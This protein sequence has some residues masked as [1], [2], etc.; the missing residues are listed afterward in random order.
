MRYSL[1][2]PFM[3]RPFAVF[4]S[5]G[6]DN[7]GVTPTP[8]SGGGKTNQDKINEI[9]DE[10][11]KAGK[12]VEW[13]DEL[14]KL[15]KNR[16]AVFEETTTVAPAPAPKKKKKKTI[17]QVSSTGQYAGDGFE[18]VDSDQGYLTR[19]YTGE[20]K[21]NNLGKDV[22]TGGTAPNELKETIAAISLNEGS[23]FA[24]SVSSATDRDILNVLRGEEI[25]SPSYA[26][27]VGQEDYQDPAP[28]PVV[29]YTP[30]TPS[31]EESLRP[32]ARPEDVFALGD[33]AAAA[34]DY[35]ILDPDPEEDLG[36]G[37][38]PIST[39][40]GQVTMDPVTGEI[41]EYGT[42]EAEELP[43]FTYD[44]RGPEQLP[45][46]E[47]K[48]SSLRPVVSPDLDTLDVDTLLDGGGFDLDT[49][50]FRPSTSDFVEPVV[51]VASTDQMAGLDQLLAMQE[52]RDKQ[53][54]LKRGIDA[55][56]PGLAS[57]L[58]EAARPQEASVG[59]GII[60]ALKHAAI[61]A[62]ENVGSMLGGIGSYLETTAPLSLFQEGGP[63]NVNPMHFLADQL[64]KRLIPEEDRQ[65]LLLGADL[66][67]PPS[68]P[69]QVLTDAGSFLRDTASPAI[70]EFL[71]PKSGKSAVV[72]DTFTD[73]TVQDVGDGE[74]QTGGEAVQ[75]LVNTTFGEAADVGLDMLLS[76]NPVTRVGSAALNAGE[77]LT[78]FQEA[79]SRKIDQS[80]I[81]GQLD[82]NPIY[83]KALNLQNGD[84]DKALQVVKNYSYDKGYPQIVAAGSLD[85]VIPGVS[86]GNALYS[87]AK[88]GLK[89]GAVEGAQGSFESYTAI[90]SINKALGT[91]FDVT[92]NIVGQGITEGLA[93]AGVG[94]AVG[95]GLSHLPVSQQ[96]QAADAA[97]GN[98][99]APPGVGPSAQTDPNPVA[100]A[101]VVQTGVDPTQFATSGQLASSTVPT[102]FDDPTVDTAPPDGMATSM[103]IMAAQEIIDNSIAETGTVPVE[104]MANLQTATG[105]SM[106]LLNDMAM[107]STA[108]PPD[109]T[110]PSDLTD[111]VT[112]IG[113][114][115]NVQVQPLPS[116]ETMLTNTATG[117]QELVPEGA[118]LANAI[119]VFD[120]VTTPGLGPLDLTSDMRAPE[121]ATTRIDP[122]P[123]DLSGIP[124]RL[125]LGGR[126]DTV[127]SV[128]PDAEVAM[129]VPERPASP[130]VADMEPRINLTDAVSL[131]PGNIAGT[132]DVDLSSIPSRLT[133]TD[134]KSMGPVSD[135]QQGI[136]SLIDM[137][138]KDYADLEAEYGTG[139]RPGW[140]SAELASIQQDISALQSQDAES[141]P[142]LDETPP[143][144]PAP[145]IDQQPAP[146]PISE[147]DIF[148]VQVGDSINGF[149]VADTQ[150]FDGKARS[151]NL[152]V[153]RNDG[154][155][156]TLSGE[157]TT[158]RD[159]EYGEP[160]VMVEGPYGDKGVVTVKVGSKIKGGESGARDNY[161]AASVTL[162]GYEGP[163]D[164][165][166][167]AN[168]ALENWQQNYENIASSDELE[169]NA[170]KVV[171]VGEDQAPSMEELVGEDQAPSMEELVAERK[172]AILEHNETQSDES[173]QRIADA[174]A[175]ISAAEAET[176]EEFDSTPIYEEEDTVVELPEFKSV[177]EDP[178]PE[179]KSVRETADGGAEVTLSDVLDPP[180]DPV[181]TGVGGLEGEI[182]GG[183]ISVEVKEPVV[184]EGV[185][186]EGEVPIEPSNIPKTSSTLAKTEVDSAPKTEVTPKTKKAKV[187]TEVEP[188]VPPADMPPPP[189]AQI[190]KDVEVE[191][192]AGLPF[193]F[194]LGVQRDADG[195]IITECPEGYLQVE[196]DGGPMCQRTFSINRQR[197]GASTNPYTG[198]ST[199]KR[200]GPGQKR[201]DSDRTVT[202]MPISRKA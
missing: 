47:Q 103:D 55:A 161:V 163:Q 141:A 157:P 13:N 102:A 48:Q 130:T 140:V 201:K 174:N 27:Q 99:A 168:I 53:E 82:T 148:Q 107:K 72:G 144:P 127:P 113:G 63:P 121:F 80:Y 10:A 124:S 167:A 36:L 26:A 143:P 34:V 133:L 91:D 195:N 129:D 153:R 84:V 118:D 93:G 71:D 56:P 125:T 97:L 3:V 186:I 190:T 77:Q 83:Q 183:D 24:G 60:D 120:E 46:V 96:R 40:T 21:D 200:R 175:A 149:S 79:I 202:V 69:S 184:D 156:R 87:A 192:P 151:S 169:S 164:I 198:V 134:A 152:D 170:A 177:R 150:G 25:G 89:R 108:F 2:N 189:P 70:E 68:L 128:V 178:E 182:L 110:T 12:E 105:A 20:G 146:P 101:P 62:P 106:E 159:A 11:K 42:P 28:E 17:G 39:G 51:D 65:D 81:A 30:T 104:V 139:I 4:D 85:A 123:V 98:L 126:E 117:R 187:L 49:T 32:Q 29:D 109:S 176:V 78:G 31:L 33:P 16:D 1:Y 155:G 44:P 131:S 137:K 66:D 173:M 147:R 180:A 160:V 196:G 95:A 115:G 181:E 19:T 23:D 9:Y 38:E 119:A 199:G 75:G 136:R 7:G 6:D 116:G 158:I 8:S 197:A 92:E 58:E 64:N 142:A 165:D 132:T 111:E 100:P 41:T 14:N 5:D 35:S 76:L 59:G 15:V 74:V 86:K 191:L 88:E 138:R 172:A 185:T 145:E 18:W 135:E 154:E 73:L 194:K 61:T 54:A 57:N 94:A 90:D 122:T 112:G 179:F 67:A 22:I 50:E 37:T 171:S 193:M 188:P 52:M 43:E 114:G 45:S 162:S 166:Q